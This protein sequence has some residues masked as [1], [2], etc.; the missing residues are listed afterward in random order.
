M[1]ITPKPPKPTQ[2]VINYKGNETENEVYQIILKS[3]DEMIHAVD[4]K[5]RLTLVRAKLQDALATVE[6]K[7]SKLWMK[8]NFVEQHKHITEE[9]QRQA[10]WTEDGIL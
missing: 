6:N 3:V 7:L 9:K 2:I 5:D 10:K 1:D 4:S 8:D